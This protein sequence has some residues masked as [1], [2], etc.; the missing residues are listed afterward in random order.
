MSG[1]PLRGAATCRHPNR[2]ID[3]RAVPPATAVVT[4]ERFAQHKAKLLDV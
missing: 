1:H 4:D 3:G 2:V